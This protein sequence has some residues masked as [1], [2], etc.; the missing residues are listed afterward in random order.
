MST[1]T[2]EEQER[3]AKYQRESEAET[4]EKTDLDGLSNP[5]LAQWQA[6]Q[7]PGSRGA[8]L[9]SQQWKIRL[10]NRQLKTSRKLAWLS[11]FFGL[12][13]VV[14]GYYLRTLD[15]SIAPPHGVVPKTPA[16]THAEQKEH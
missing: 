6:E 9:A 2:P 10:L 15:I 13:G 5:A 11:G 8:I 4:W 3:N 12:A 1:P 7:K 14:L 16:D